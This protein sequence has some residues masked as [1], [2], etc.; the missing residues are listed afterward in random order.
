[1]RTKALRSLGQIVTSDPSILAAV[2]H[3]PRVSSHLLTRSQNNVRAA[4]ETH[5]L[6]S[7]PAVRDAAVELIGKYMIDSPAV[8]EEYYPKIADRIAVRSAS[9]SAQR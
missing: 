4:I 6:D 1:M 7:S 8:A 9:F 5:L 2:R 3:N